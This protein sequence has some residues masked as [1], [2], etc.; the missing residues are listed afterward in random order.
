MKIGVLWQPFFMV[1]NP[2]RNMN[3]KED[4][5]GMSV[6][7]IFLLDLDGESSPIAMLLEEIVK[8]S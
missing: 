5:N 2:L 4:T 6:V 1:S 8:I 7:K 3:R